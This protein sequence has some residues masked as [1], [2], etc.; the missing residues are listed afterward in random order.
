MRTIRPAS[1]AL[2]DI[3]LLCPELDV[4]TDPYRHVGGL[5]VEISFGEYIDFV[6]QVLMNEN[7]MYLSTAELKRLAGR[8]LEGDKDSERELYRVYVLD[9]CAAGLKELA[10]AYRAGYDATAIMYTA[11]YE[12]VTLQNAQ[13]IPMNSKAFRDY[14]WRIRILGYENRQ[15]M[16]EVNRKM[17]VFYIQSV[18]AALSRYNGFFKAPAAI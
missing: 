7:F 4:Y 14:L 12:A 17:F 13:L 2:A 11:P 3:L 16:S 9:V 5:T 15:S 18:R 8:T 1:S 6:L 10:L